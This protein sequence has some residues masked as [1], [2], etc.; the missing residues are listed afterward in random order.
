MPCWPPATRALHGETLA[1]SQSG[2]KTH[3]QELKGSCLEGRRVTRGCLE[4][5]VGSP[6]L[7]LM[8]PRHHL[9]YSGHYLPFKR[10]V[11][12]GVT[13]GT[14]CRATTHALTLPAWPSRFETPLTVSENQASRKPRATWHMRNSTASSDGLS[15]AYLTPLPPLSRSPSPEAR[16]ELPRPPDR[17]D[18]P[19]QRPT[20]V[21]S[22][23]CTG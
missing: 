12:R 21:S 7:P 17:E 9:H 18:C 16:A 15:I 23:T 6:L 8:H 20:H 2:S 11:V 10:H 4:P 14:E 3:A 13:R 5:G 1:P 22:V 19:A